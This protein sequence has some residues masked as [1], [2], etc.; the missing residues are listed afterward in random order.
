M[1]VVFF[2]EFADLALQHRLVDFFE[3]FLDS[4]ELQKSE[5]VHLRERQEIPVFMLVLG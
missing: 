2:H 1:L 4:V 5:L 3:V